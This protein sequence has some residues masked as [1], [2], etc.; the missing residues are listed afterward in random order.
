MVK[1]PKPI[2]LSGTVGAAVLPD[3]V[4]P[5]LLALFNMKGGDGF[6]AVPAVTHHTQRRGRCGVRGTA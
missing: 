2:N 1:C 5:D 6:G 4:R 3:L